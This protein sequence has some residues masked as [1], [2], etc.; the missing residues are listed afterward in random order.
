MKKVLMAT[1]LLA[2]SG[3][4]HAASELQQVA[5]NPTSFI[6]STDFLALEY[7]G[8]GDVTAHVSSVDLQLGFGNATTSGCEA[9]DFAGF[10]A[11]TIAL[12]QRGTCTFEQKA[13]NA[14]VA[15]AVGVLI[16]N[17]GNDP[18]RL[19]VFG[20]TL[21]ANFI[22]DIPVF[23]LSYSLGAQLA[24]TA[25]LSVRMFQDVRVVPTPTPEPGSLLLL[26]LGLCALASGRRR[27]AA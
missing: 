27:K 22:Y 18:T 14:M 10:A 5:P 16:F 23:A 1:V 13:V 2:A 25:G 11:G 21:T 9:A 20:G 7:S 12:I 15:G 26:G 4:A 8:A 24:Q 19:D 17:Q 6:E 3:A